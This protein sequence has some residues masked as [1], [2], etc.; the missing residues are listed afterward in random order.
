MKKILI[1]ALL[2]LAMLASC[3]KKTDTTMT[4]SAAAADSAKMAAPAPAAPATAMAS[5]ND[6]INR[7]PATPP[8]GGKI[9]PPPKQ[10]PKVTGTK[11]S[12]SISAPG[13]AGSP[14]QLNTSNGMQPDTVIVSATFSGPDQG[15]LNVSCPAWGN[16]WGCGTQSNNTCTVTFAMAASGY[17]VSVNAF[18][19]QSG[20]ASVSNNPPSTQQNNSGTDVTTYVMGPDTCVVTIT[21]TGHPV[22]H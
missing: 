1:P 6:T 18:L 12:L 7:H 10:H 2:V 11:G 17:T 5:T 9:G 3:S 20:W 22:A 19:L 16:G 13:N 21:D 4:D 8:K 15:Q 14:I